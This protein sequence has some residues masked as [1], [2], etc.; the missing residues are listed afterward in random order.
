[1]TWRLTALKLVPILVD[2]FVH[3]ELRP[4]SFARAAHRCAL[5]EAAETLE[6]SARTAGSSV[7]TC[8]EV[9]LSASIPAI[10]ARVPRPSVRS[11]NDLSAG[12]RTP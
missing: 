9:A 1:M 2:L 12:S 10:S 5:S 4:M 7:I 3:E 8:A 11:T 6:A